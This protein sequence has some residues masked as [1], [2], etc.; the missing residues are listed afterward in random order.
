M[1]TLGLLRA[2]TVGLNVSSATKLVNFENPIKTIA[3]HECVM[4]GTLDS[5]SVANEIVQK[6]LSNFIRIYFSKSHKYSKK[7]EMFTP[8]SEKCGEV[9]EQWNR[10]C[11][12]WTV[13]SMNNFVIHDQK[14]K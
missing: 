7:L 13:I 5:F 1:C 4:R 2:K 12:N 3:V 14:V 11:V 9:F 6:L 8:S 10:I